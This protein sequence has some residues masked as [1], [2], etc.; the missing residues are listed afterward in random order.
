VSIDAVRI[1]TDRLLLRPVRLADRD[2]IFERFT[3]AVTRYLHPST[4]RSP[5]D[6][7]AFLREAC[8]RMA[9]GKDLVCA[10]AARGTPDD[11]AGLCGIHDLPAAEPELGIW[12]RER[13][14]G[15]G[16]GLEAVRAIRDWASARRGGV[17]TFLYPV[18]EANTPSRRIAERLAG[19]TDGTI[20]E[21]KTADGRV[22]RIVT[23]RVPFPV[24]PAN[25]PVPGAV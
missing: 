5:A 4:P 20:R 22:L 2:A 7:E 24:P 12:I 10:V 17:A 13:D 23:Y 16:Y 25:P 9:A 18:D 14:W 3:A 21:T 6:T 8:A 11:L 19:T 15:R 1:E